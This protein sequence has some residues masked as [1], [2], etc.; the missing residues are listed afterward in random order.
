MFRHGHKGNRSHGQNRTWIEF[1]AH[2][3][4]MECQSLELGIQLRRSLPL[5]KLT[6]LMSCQQTKSQ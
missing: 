6:K 4:Q 2:N 1:K 3:P 5:Q